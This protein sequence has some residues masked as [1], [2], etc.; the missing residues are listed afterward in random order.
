MR[1]VVLVL[2]ALGAPVHAQVASDDFGIE[3]FRLSIDR[4]GVLDVE[5]ASVPLH[6][7]WSA[8]VFVG[9]AHEP[10]VLYDKDMQPIEALVDRRLT[11]GLVGS[12]ALFDRVQIGAGLDLVGYQHGSDNSPTME[13]LP[14]AGLGDA[15]L[16]AKLV[17]SRVGFLDVAFVPTLTV[18]AGSARGYLREDGVTFA[19]AVAVSGVRDRLRVAANLGYRLKPRVEVAGLV[20]DDEVFARVGAGFSLPAVELWWSTSFASPVKNTASNKLAIEMLAGATRDVTSKVGVFLAGGVGLQNGFGTPDWRALAGVRLSYE[21]Q[22]PRTLVVEPDRTPIVVAPDPPAVKAA[23]VTVSVVDF[24]KRPIP[25]ATIFMNQLDKKL[26]L[27]DG[28]IELDY[29]GGELVVEA[30]APQ[31]QTLTGVVNVAPGT[32][33]TLEIVLVRSVRQGQLRGQVLSFSGKPLAAT[34]VVDGKTIQTDVDGQYAIDL[35]AG[36]FEITIESPGHLPQKRTVSVKLDGVT[37]LN[38]DLRATK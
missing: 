16:V 32:A 22:P 27:V 1:W 25:N 30:S 7:S 24:D 2:V 28:K 17:V 3:R 11:T 21:T 14:K 15:R 4:S 26:D 19:P 18:P 34:I 36:S 8:G 29:P 12:I 38:V 20:N 33:G 5:S 31:Y 35:P 6:K 10:L 37:V 23:T 13:D 9:F